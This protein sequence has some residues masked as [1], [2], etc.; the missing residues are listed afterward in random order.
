MCNSQFAICHLGVV[1]ISNPQLPTS[2]LQSPISDSQSPTSTIAR[3]AAIISLGNVASR[4]L[5]L[6]R[7]MVIAY[8]FGATGLVSVFRVAATIIQT[9]YDFL[10]GG[11]VSAALVPVF[12]EFAERRDE[13][14]RVASVVINVLAIFLALAVIILE[15]FAPQLVWI[16]G[17][18][19]DA[20]L[21][22]AAVEMIRLILPALF[23]LGMSGVVTSLLYALNRF[24]Y[25]AFTTAAYNAGIVLVAL[26]LA[27]TFGI[28]S[29]IVGILIGS[30][31]Q[32]LLQLPGLRGMNYRFAIDFAH[33]A[34]KKILLL[35]APVV[36]G[37]AV[38]VFSVAVD[39][40]LA[41][42]TG[43]QSLAWMQNATVLIQFPLGLI[44]TAISFAILPT[45][46]QNSE[47][48]FE[49]TDGNSGFRILNSEFQT[50]LAF[51]IKLVI[52]LILPATVGLFILARPI[53]AL[54]FEH[55]AF[56][57]HDTVQTARA[58]QFYLVGLPFAAIDQPLV[59]AFYARKNTLTPNLVAIAG[60]AIYLAFAF[61]LVDS[62]GMIGLVIAN[63]AM[64][65]AHALLM[66]WLTHTRLGGLGAQGVIA[67]TLKVAIASL[68]MGALAFA[69]LNALADAADWI[70]VIT[71]TPIAGAVY[72]AL[73]RVLRVR[74]AERVWEIA[75]ARLTR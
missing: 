22:T 20:E 67:L 40:N 7:E 45:L 70:V 54:L 71:T 47:G 58:L 43:A 23:F 74:E 63:S 53:V 10:I 13:F 26:V 56:T 37:L 52:L 1:P 6:A 64:L 66:V 34:L 60:V 2:N 57:A 31:S 42:H 24:T 44:A 36:L 59:F 16:L 46:S 17:G 75:R 5:G 11:M 15:I 33:P 4:V 65:T 50:T 32:V 8:L 38:S 39:R 72:I 69:L 25:P 35:Y 51:G 9:L 14:W 29:L 19:Y 18:G 48:Q 12:S 55:G 27:P 49:V 41:S 61:A 68:A 30:A 21:Q 73:L 3:A 62:Q 28:T